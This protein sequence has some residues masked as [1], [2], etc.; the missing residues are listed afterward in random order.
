MK[1]HQKR[2]FRNRVNRRIYRKPLKCKCESCQKTYVDIWDG[3]KNGLDKNFH[4]DYI[5]I[6]QMDGIAYFDKPVDGGNN[7]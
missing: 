6:N 2:W 3:R 4:A 7:A 1:Y 5:F